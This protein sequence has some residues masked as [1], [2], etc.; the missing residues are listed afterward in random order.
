M[1]EFYPRKAK[2]T[3]LDPPRL[4]LPLEFSVTKAKANDWP[5]SLAIKIEKGFSIRVFL[6]TF[7][8]S[9]SQQIKHK[10]RMSL[11][12]DSHARGIFFL[13]TLLLAP[14]QVSALDDG[15]VSA[16][17]DMQAEWGTQLGWTGSPSCS[18]NGVTCNQKGN[19]FELYVLFLFHEATNPNSPQLSTQTSLFI[20]IF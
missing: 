15:E 2:K 7:F 13:I 18:W 16:L 20:V 6:S 9:G 3:Q 12:Q 1:V 4:L 14:N 5:V 11:F 8:L 10:R 19:V 17:K